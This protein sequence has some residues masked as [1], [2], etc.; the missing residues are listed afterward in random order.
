MHK[1]AQNNPSNGRPDYTLED[2]LEDG[3]YVAL[4]GVKLKFT[5]RSN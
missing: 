5:L 4:G 3:L 2:L 1:S